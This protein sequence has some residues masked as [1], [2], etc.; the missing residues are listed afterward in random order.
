LRQKH[1]G[2]QYTQLNRCLSYLEMWRK[3]WGL[4]N[5]VVKNSLR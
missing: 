3:Q 4:V 1:G 2:V 5:M